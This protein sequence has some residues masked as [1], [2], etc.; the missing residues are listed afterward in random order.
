MEGY[1]RANPL[2]V[3]YEAGDDRL[4]LTLAECEDLLKRMEGPDRRWVVWLDRNATWRNL[5]FDRPLPTEQDRVILLQCY[6]AK[7]LSHFACFAWE[8]ERAISMQYNDEVTIV[9]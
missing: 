6:D 5:R 3:M 8:C 4:P 2:I 1:N 7:R 9:L